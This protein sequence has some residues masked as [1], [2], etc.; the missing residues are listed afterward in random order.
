[1]KYL[2]E[3]FL[4]QEKERLLMEY[5]CQ[6]LAEVQEVLKARIKLKGENGKKSPS[7]S[8]LHT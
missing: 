7:K 8:L 4:T 5:N 6:T 2:D 1:L 3:E